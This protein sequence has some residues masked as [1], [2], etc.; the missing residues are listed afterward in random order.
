M[1]DASARQ[2]ETE[3]IKQFLE[4]EEYKIKDSKQ[5]VEDELKEVQPLID[6]AKTAVE[7]ISK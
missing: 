5:Q 7:G 3:K 1:G 4:S 6:Q 2:A